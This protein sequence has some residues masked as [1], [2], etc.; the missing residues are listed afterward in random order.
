MYPAVTLVL[1]GIRGL[2]AADLVAVLL[3]GFR[4]PV[5]VLERRI[6]RGL[7]LCSRAS[8]RGGLG[9][10]GTGSG[11]RG[12]GEGSYLSGAVG[13]GGA[14][15]F[16]LATGAGGVTVNMFMSLPLLSRW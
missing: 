6:V 5:H 13:E 12:R 16:F 7:H 3:L 10:S 9:M 1:A 14:G 2:V 11:A 15:G 8:N 4:L